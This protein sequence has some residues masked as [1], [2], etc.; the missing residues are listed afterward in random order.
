MESSS[1]HVTTVFSEPIFAE[2]GLKAGG[3]L[4]GMS[5]RRLGLWLG[6]Y[7]RGPEFRAPA[8]TRATP[9]SPAPAR[10]V[11]PRRDPAQIGSTIG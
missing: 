3:H 11:A 10:S 5:L 2:C 7:E 9:K 4:S 6:I 8:L 1:V